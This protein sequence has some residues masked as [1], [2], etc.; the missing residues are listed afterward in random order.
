MQNLVNNR[1]IKHHIFHK[2]SDVVLKN[3]K[4]FTIE[5][6]SK[7]LDKSN[8]M[9]RSYPSKII[10]CNLLDVHSV[11]IE[12]IDF[13]R[14]FVKNIEQENSVKCNIFAYYPPNGIIDW[15]TNE[16]I[17]HWNAICTFSANGDSFFEYLKNKQQIKV[18]DTKGW[19]VKLIKWTNAEPLVWHRA[20]SNT[21][22]IT[23]TFSSPNKI[24]V[25]NFIKKII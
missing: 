3:K 16:N 20:V 13:T 24:D 6:I 18:Y 5:N 15:H 22:R 12:T 14:S 23:V 4:K 1:T 25:E 7:E 10:L 17:P 11:D 19:S 8:K 2:L 9:Y 21:D